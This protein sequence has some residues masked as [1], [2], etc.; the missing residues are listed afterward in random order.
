MIEKQEETKT[1]CLNQPPSPWYYGRAYL[2]NQLIA[3]G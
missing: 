1:G 3:L 2:Q